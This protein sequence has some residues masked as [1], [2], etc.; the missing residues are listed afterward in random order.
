MPF[1]SPA[2]PEPAPAGSLHGRGG[3][4][5]LCVQEPLLEI[6]MERGGPD[7][8]GSRHRGHHPGARAG[9]PA[10]RADSAGLSCA[11]AGSHD[12]APERLPGALP[13]GPRLCQRHEGN[14]LGRRAHHDHAHGLVAACRGAHS[15]VEPGGAPRERV[16]HHGLQQCGAVHALLLPDARGRR[17]LGCLHPAPGAPASRVVYPLCRSACVGPAGVHKPHPHRH[18]GG[19]GGSTR[20]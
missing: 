16:V 14:A 9:E 4:A 5:V 2:D 13:D 8:C 6:R 19:R 15:P 3:T 17:L 18:R 10:E 20:S 1:A 11:Q 7:D 12:P